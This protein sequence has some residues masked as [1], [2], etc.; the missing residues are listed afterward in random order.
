MPTINGVHYYAIY[1]IDVSLLR[2][3]RVSTVSG[4]GAFQKKKYSF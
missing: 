3:L 1:C 4:L 2:T